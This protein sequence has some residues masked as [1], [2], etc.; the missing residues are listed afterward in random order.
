MVDWVHWHGTAA[1]SDPSGA[2]ERWGP[3]HDGRQ[4]GGHLALE[5]QKPVPYAPAPRT[6]VAIAA[7]GRL[8]GQS[9][10]MVLTEWPL[11]RFGRTWCEALL[12]NMPSPRNLAHRI[13]WEFMGT[14]VASSQ[15]FG[16]LNVLHGH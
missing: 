5:R 4:G 7:Q 13:K 3:A 8:V 16:W 6:G 1:S 2:S 15:K 12:Y 11:Y 10:Q 14:V 9:Q